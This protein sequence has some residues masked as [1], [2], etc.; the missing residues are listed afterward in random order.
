MSCFPIPDDLFWVVRG[1]SRTG[2]VFASFL[3]VGNRGEPISGEGVREGVRWKGGE[4]VVKRSGDGRP[5]R[6]EGVLKRSGYW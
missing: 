2:G 6:R 3:K 4:V 5:F 1:A